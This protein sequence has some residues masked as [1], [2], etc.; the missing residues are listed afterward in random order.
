[1]SASSTPPNA[2][3]TGVAN[4]PRK[5]TSGA[6]RAIIAAYAI[7]ALAA[8]A[9]SIVQIARDF[10]TAPLAYALSGFAAVV[11]VAATVAL[12]H[13]ARTLAWVTI[14]IE[15]VGVVCVGM[16]TGWHPELFPKDTVWSGFGKGYGYV[17][18]ILPIFGFAWLESTG[19]DQARE[20][21]QRARH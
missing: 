15:F 13:G 10:E 12:A 1:M 6:G 3:E 16:L 21:G 18:A 19:R 4:A 9:R 5:T 7:L 20:K 17:P 8:S 2:S 11:Y 14:T